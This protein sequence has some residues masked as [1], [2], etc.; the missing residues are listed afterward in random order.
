MQL[1]NNINGETNML[2]GTIL[3][4]DSDSLTGNTISFSGDSIMSNDYYMDITHPIGTPDYNYGLTGNTISF[5][6]DSIMSKEY[7]ERL[8]TPDIDHVNLQKELRSLD[9]K[10][11][12]YTKDV[13][14]QRTMSTLR[15]VF[16][17]EVNKNIA[18]I[19]EKD[20]TAILRSSVDIFKRYVCNH[21][22]DIRSVSKTFVT[23]SI[24][25]AKSSK[26]S[27]MSNVVL[28]VM[29]INAAFEI[30]DSSVDEQKEKCK[31]YEKTR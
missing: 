19:P 10:F 23:A 3:D 31:P 22:E 8:L 11:G 6:G 2:I 16:E 14:V 9:R 29:G 12:S 20:T 25:L 27:G 1:A 30:I 18:T 21:L 17:N 4:W 24:S 26:I 28:K 7:R 13:D 15:D 5:S